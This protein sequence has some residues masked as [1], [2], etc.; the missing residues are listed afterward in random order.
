LFVYA[1]HSV[2]VSAATR[3]GHPAP[4]GTGSKKPIQCG[5]AANH[6]K[7]ANGEV[8][9]GLTADDFIVEDDGFEQNPVQL[10]DAAESDPISLVV[11]IQTGRRA[12]REFPRM[13]GLNSLL[14]PVFDQPGS[15][16]A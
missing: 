1:H 13:R 8:V 3:D 7:D 16:V 5:A 14:N 11:A 15:R 2:P 4:A 12:K 10:D 6:G 9:Y